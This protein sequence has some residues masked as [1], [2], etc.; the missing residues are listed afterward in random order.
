MCNDCA[1]EFA[2]HFWAQ[3]WNKIIIRQQHS[4]H[5]KINTHSSGIKLVLF[6][7][8][9]SFSTVFGLVG[10]KPGFK[11]NGFRIFLSKK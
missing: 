2:L 9:I 10:V 6:L 4:N 3:Y 1:Y 11:K 5:M 8:I 7:N